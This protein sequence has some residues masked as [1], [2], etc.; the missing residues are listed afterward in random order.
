MFYIIIELVLIYTH[1][2]K[3]DFLGRVINHL[4][5]G[6]ARTFFLTLSLANIYIS[7]I[8]CTAHT[9]IYICIASKYEQISPTIFQLY[10][11]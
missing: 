4:D 8:H 2:T 7:H 11:L 9:S 10:S 6:N 5:E 1:L 3:N